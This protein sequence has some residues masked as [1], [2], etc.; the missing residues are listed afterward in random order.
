MKIKILWANEFVKVI[1]I[2]LIGTKLN[3]SKTIHMSYNGF[4]FF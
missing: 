4:V 1:L 2:D 3:N